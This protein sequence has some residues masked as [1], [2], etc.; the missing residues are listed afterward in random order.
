MCACRCLAL[1][2]GPHMWQ[3]QRRQSLPGAVPLQSMFDQFLA[4]MKVRAC[5]APC[6][7][8]HQA[9]PAHLPLHATQAPFSSP[10]AAPSTAL[11]HVQRQQQ[12]G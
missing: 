7:W 3:Q 2:V 12:Q 10:S 1:L 8:L 4:A 5:R 11:H 6:S 9:R